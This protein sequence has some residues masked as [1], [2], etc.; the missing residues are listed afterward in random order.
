MMHVYLDDKN[1]CAECL[2]KR[3]LYNFRRVVHF[4]PCIF[5]GP[6]MLSN[7]AHKFRADEI[8]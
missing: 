8:K 6:F 4:L 5:G 2:V 7:F 3:C 1:F